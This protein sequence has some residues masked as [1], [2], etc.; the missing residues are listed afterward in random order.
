MLFDY[1]TR[2]DLDMEK[3]SDSCLLF[4]IFPLSSVT[5]FPFSETL[6]IVILISF[7]LPNK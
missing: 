5:I 3:M 7:R 2:D 1:P 6:K 4:A